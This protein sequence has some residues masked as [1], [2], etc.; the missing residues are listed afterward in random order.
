M[1]APLNNRPPKVVNTIFYS[2]TGIPLYIEIV[3][4]SNTDRLEYSGVSQND[5]PRSGQRPTTDKPRGT[6]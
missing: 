6:D 1:I 3:H 2:T 5:T 4:Q